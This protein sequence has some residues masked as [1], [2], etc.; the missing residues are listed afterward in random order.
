[1]GKRIRRIIRRRKKGRNMDFQGW[2]RKIDLDTKEEF[3]APTPPPKTIYWVPG[4]GDRAPTPRE[5]QQALQEHPKAELSESGVMLYEFDVEKTNEP[6]VDLPPGCYDYKEPHHTKPE[7][8]VPTTLRDDTIIKMPGITRKIVKD[9]RVF[10]ANEKIYREIGIQYRRGIL[11]YGPPGNG[12][13][14]SLREIIKEEIPSN[15]IT[16][17]LHSLPSSVMLKKLQ[18][19]H[20]M[21]VIIFE[22]LAAIV[23]QYDTQIERILDFLDGESSLDNALIFATTNY[24]EM[25]PGNIVNRPSRF[26]RLIK[27]GN[28]DAATCTDLL[29]LYLSR[30]P[31]EEEVKSV[32]DLSVAA[33]KEAAIISRLHEVSVSKAVENI[34][35]TQDL[36]KNDFAESSPIG[37][38]PR[39]RFHIMDEFDF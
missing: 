34:K 25:L 6:T 32:E 37:L 22:E 7:R 4:P 33:V 26:D 19:E 31:T 3:F 27:V 8:L 28:P 30:E 24:P 36:V 11:L 17:F 35:A 15:A 1:M 18:E 29:R 9:V 16:I 14:T 10:L 38:A 13:T 20:R 39:N 23:K 5:I 2:F 12:K 21:K